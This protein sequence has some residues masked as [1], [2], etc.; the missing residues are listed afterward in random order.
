MGK[1]WDRFKKGALA[2]STGG[3]SLLLDKT[4]PNKQAGV[5]EYDA[6]PGIQL[7]KDAQARK[8]A[9]VKQDED[10][11]AAQKA[12]AD[13]AEYWARHNTESIEEL[14]ADGLTYT[15]RKNDQ[16]N[17]GVVEQQWGI[18]GGEYSE[19]GAAQQWS[20]QNRDVYDHRG[21][22]EVTSRRVAGKLEQGAETNAG[23]QYWDKVAG[24]FND[25]SRT[26]VEANL[27][28]YYDRA[29]DRGAG[30]INR[31]LAARGQFGSTRGMQ[32]IGDYGA[33][34]QADRANREAQYGLQRSADELA[35][36]RGGADIAFRAADTRQSYLTDAASQAQAAQ[37]Q[38]FDR[39]GQA[40]GQLLQDDA[41]SLQNRNSGMIAASSAQGARDNRIQQGA[42]NQLAFAS[43]LAGFGSHGTDSNLLQDQQQA[44][45]GL[46][47]EDDA[48]NRAYGAEEARY[49]NILASGNQ[50]GLAGGYYDDWK[51]N[52]GKG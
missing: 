34:L 11:A 10:W 38:Q 39:L 1:A 52:Q 46:A 37:A 26:D 13:D 22:G 9:K 43:I 48:Y 41:Y 3:A 16:T 6:G 27:G 25:G 14:N 40:H 28:G 23:S 33:A 7:E 21:T 19:P 30:Q 42:D 49:Q 29:F 47:A 50:L 12:A 15:P 45:V 36:T 51:K 17:M 2:V 31:Q 8:A 44:E 5:T 35:W 24:R 20:E 18:V 32:Q 4:N